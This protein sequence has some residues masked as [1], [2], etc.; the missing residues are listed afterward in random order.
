MTTLELRD[1]MMK[2]HKVDE[3]WISID[4]DVQP[5]PCSLEDAEYFSVDGVSVAVM[6]AGSDK[7]NWI[8]LEP[9]R[10]HARP[11]G[12][13]PGKS[14]IRNFTGSNVT[15]KP[16]ETAS[17][18][19]VREGTAAVWLLQIIG[20]LFCITLYGLLIG[21][22]LILVGESIARRFKCSRCGGIVDKIGHV[23]PHCS[24]RFE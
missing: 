16:P 8:P 6:H 23:C 5:S 21:I 15:E 22:P 13:L 24:A 19:K 20:L 4:G 7:G 11:M 12:S 2:D 9:T 1:W 3:W 14:N 17:K 18:I 10:S